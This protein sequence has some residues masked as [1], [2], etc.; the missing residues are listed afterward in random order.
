LAWIAGDSVY[1]DDRPLR[2]WLQA[3]RQPYVLAISP[4]EQLWVGHESWTHAELLARLAAVPG[5]ATAAGRAVRGR[6]GMTGSASS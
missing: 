3:Q 5:N 4:V 2:Q 1:G 6:A